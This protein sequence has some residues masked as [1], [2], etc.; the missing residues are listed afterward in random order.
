MS[1]PYE[2]LAG[3][4]TLYLAPVGEAYP[5]IGAAPG[6]NWVKVGTSGTANYADDGVTVN[7]T[8]KNETAR[9]AGTTG[10]IKAWRTEEDLM[11]GLT[12]W[13]MTLEQYATAMNGAG[14]ATVAAGSG[15]P[16][17]KTM[18]LTQGQEVKTYAL[19]AVGYSAYDNAMPAQ[20]E[21]PRCFQ[22][23]SPKPAF[24]KG[25]PA[26]L[27]LEFTALED[28]SAASDDQ[29]FGRLVMQHQAAL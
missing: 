14:V 10:P 28:L 27:D 5:A 7:H 6:D 19:L 4:L 20:Y 8:Q 17:T 22:S 26:A 13:D 23:A 18:G 12:L 16:G 3:P 2:V 21:V 24:K 29:R 15:T 1:D 9:P 25:T 11:I